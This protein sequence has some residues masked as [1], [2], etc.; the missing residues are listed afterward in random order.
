ME[1]PFDQRKLQKQIEDQ[2][3]AHLFCF[4]SSSTNCK[5]SF[6]KDILESFRNKVI[7]LRPDMDALS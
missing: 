5:A 2:I 4:C 3:N 6:Y 1:A 7:G